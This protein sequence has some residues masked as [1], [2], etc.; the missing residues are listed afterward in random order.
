MAVKKTTVEIC[1]CERCGHT[2]QKRGDR[3]LPAAC[4]KCKSPLWNEKKKQKTA[5]DKKEK[6]E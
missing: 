2:W 1:E 3:D 6:I 5:E 4:P